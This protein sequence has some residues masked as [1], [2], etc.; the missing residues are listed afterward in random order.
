MYHGHLPIITEA[1]SMKQ[2]KPI[3]RRI[4]NLEIKITSV[5]NNGTVYRWGYWRYLN[6]EAW[7]KLEGPP[8]QGRGGIQRLIRR[9]QAHVQSHL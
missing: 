8:E 9:I 7:Q 2:Q 1:T 3:F 6:D 4:D 5:P